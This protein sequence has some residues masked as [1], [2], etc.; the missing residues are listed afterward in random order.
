MC[1]L[2]ERTRPPDTRECV[3]CGFM[4]RTVA[5]V[6]AR[7]GNRRVSLIQVFILS[8]SL[9]NTLPMCSV[10][11][12]R[13][14]HSARMHFVKLF[15]FLSPNAKLS[16][17]APGV[18]PP[19]QT[20]WVSSTHP[21]GCLRM[22]N[23]LWPCPRCRGFCSIYT[24]CA[25]HV[26]RLERSLHCASFTLTLLVLWVTYGEAVKAARFHCM[27]MDIITIQTL[28]VLEDVHRR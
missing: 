16:M 23:T 10:C 15:W 19:T 21:C 20:G 8:L 11:P 5:W 18:D 2:R 27:R 4:G 6:P 24:L 25:V 14:A 3:A 26:Q 12:Q 17:T 28:L 13:C 22:G 7:L 9:C 1:C